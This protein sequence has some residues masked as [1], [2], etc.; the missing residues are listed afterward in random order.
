MSFV[1]LPP[2]TISSYSLFF[3]H[4][5]IAFQG[6]GADRI[7]RAAG[8]MESIDKFLEKRACHVASSDPRKCAIRVGK[9]FMISIKKI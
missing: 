7:S 2:T 3:I 9:R 5:C 4:V 1:V 6:L 8:G